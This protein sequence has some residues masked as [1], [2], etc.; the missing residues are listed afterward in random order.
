[1]DNMI[2]AQKVAEFLGINLSQI[3]NLSNSGKLRGEF[4]DG[5][6]YITAD[7]LS[8]LVQKEDKFSHLA[9]NLGALGIAV[10]GMPEIAVPDVPEVSVPDVEV[11]AVETPDLAFPDISDSEIEAPSIDVPE[12]EVPEM[13][14]ADVA[15]PDVS[16][17]DAPVIEETPSIEIGID[18]PEAV[19]LQAPKVDVPQPVAA[20]GG[21]KLWWLIPLLVLAGIAFYFISVAGG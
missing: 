16:L 14:V 8:K 9:G 21:F 11:P 6:Q 19:S 3:R 17:P 5:Q 2:T 13:E 18:E 12:V 20:G 10:P 15:V 4:K 1:M 7:S